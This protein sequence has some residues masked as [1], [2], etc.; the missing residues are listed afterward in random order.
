METKIKLN[1]GEKL[2]QEKHKSKGMMAQKDTY[3][4]LIV[5]EAGETVG[6]VIYEDHTS[7]KDFRRTQ[8]VKQ[9][10]NVGNVVV[11]ESW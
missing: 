11:Q 7:L 5:N 6:N 4:Y 3:Y 2:V 1:L 10:D 9:T 8:H